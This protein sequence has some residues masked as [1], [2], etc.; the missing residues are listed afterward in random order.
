MKTDRFETF[1]DAILAIIIT[2]LVLK[3]A[4]PSGASLSAIFA[5][6]TDYLTYFLSFLII[7]NVWYHNH[8]LFQIVEEI[9][10]RV[11]E[12]YAFFIFVLSLLP[13][14]ASWLGRD[15]YCLPAEICYGLI[16][17]IINILYIY[18]IRAVFKSDRYNQKLRQID[19]NPVSLY[20]PLAV[21]IIGFAVSLM[22]FVPGIYISCLVSVVCWMILSKSKRKDVEMDS[23]RF[24][25]LVDAIVAIILTVI[26]LE[27]S[28]V[29]QN[30]W[31]GLF[32]LKL[33]FIAYAISFIVCFNYWN[34]NNNT[35]SLVDKIDSNVIWSIAASLF[36]LSLIPYL[37]IFVSQNFTSLLAQSLYG[38]VFIIIILLSILKS[39][40]LMN[41]NKDNAALQKVAGNN[42]P[43]IINVSIVLAGFIMAYAFYPPAIMFSCLLAIVVVKIYM[44]LWF[45]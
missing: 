35:F 12:I 30:T 44:R 14:F 27:I 32:S 22:G 29:S 8:N 2:V 20:L 37:T 3:L 6:R 10:N 26:V 17:L 36:F 39:Y 18:S 5:L 19:Y 45:E 40:A 34:L 25:A 33:E 38:I 28:M 21:I 11:I 1:L 24:E 31:Q 4:Q 7:F 16:F 41:V 13:Y 9:D 43:V 23:V 42:A 15:L